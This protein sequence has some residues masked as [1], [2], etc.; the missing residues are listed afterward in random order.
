[1]PFISCDF[2][3]NSFSRELGKARYLSTTNI[4]FPHHTGI[5]EGLG[6][7]IGSA[8]VSNSTINFDFV[9]SNLSSIPGGNDMVFR[10][11]IVVRLGIEDRLGIL[12]RIG[13]AVALLRCAQGNEAA[14]WFKSKTGF[15]IA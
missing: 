7:L 5:G 9:I 14:G 1:L 6:W 3:I 2:S 13:C 8:H 12:V 11:G 4:E 10:R 15:C